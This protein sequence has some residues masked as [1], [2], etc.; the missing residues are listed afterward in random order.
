MRSYT[1]NCRDK[2]SWIHWYVKRIGIKLIRFNFS[3]T[4]DEF[5]GKISYIYDVMI[6]SHYVVKVINPETYTEANLLVTKKEK[7]RI[8]SGL[9]NL[10]Q[11]EWPLFLDQL[12]GLQYGVN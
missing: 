2:N 1:K 9:T 10:K 6:M 11:E 5:I 7:E 8:V 4:K 3:E 12:K